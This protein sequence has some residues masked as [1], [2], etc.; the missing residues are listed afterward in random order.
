MKLFDGGRV[1]NPRAG[2]NLPR[3]KG[4]RYRKRAGRPR[5]DAAQVGGLCDDQLAAAGAGAD[6][7]RWHRHC[8]NDC[9]LPLFRVAPPGLAIVGEGGLEHV[10]EMQKTQRFGPTRSR[11]KLAG[12]WNIA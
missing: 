9:D 6:A 12:T 11:I 3:R 10:A 1:P 2:A 4:R 8:R 7:G 5:F